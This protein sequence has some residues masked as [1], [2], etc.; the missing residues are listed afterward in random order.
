VKRGLNQF[1][2]VESAVNEAIGNSSLLKQQVGAGSLLAQAL[3][4]AFAFD[5]LPPCAAT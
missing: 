3:A 4:N 5:K 2:V 1:E